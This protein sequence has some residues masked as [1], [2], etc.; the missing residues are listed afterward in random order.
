MDGR[1]R[2]LLPALAAL[3]RWTGAGA[4]ADGGLDEFSENLQAALP[5]DRLVIAHL[6]DDGRTFTIVAE[7]ALRGPVLH[8]ER[9]TGVVAPGERY[10][11][12]EWG[13][14][15]AFAGT[16]MLVDDFL[17]D[18]RYAS[19]N[20]YEQ[21]LGDAGFRAGVIVPIRA[22]GRTIGVLTILSLSAGAYTPA[23][24]ELAQVLA[25]LAAPAIENVVLRQREQ[26]RR[27]RLAA[28]VG[29]ART[30][31]ESLHARDIFDR[32]AGTIR[33]VLD[34]DIMGAGLISP[35]GREIEI[36]SEFDF[37]PTTP[38]PSRVPLESF[39][40]ADRVE[41]GET[42]LIHDAP[43][44]LDA[45]LPG[46]RLVIDGGGRSVLSV[47]LWFGERAGGALYLG[48]RRPYWFDASDAEI[49]AAIAAQVVVAIQHQR[50]TEEQ[51]RLTQAEGRARRL[52]E[53][54]ESLRSEL[55][56]RFALDAVI[57]RAPALRE[58]LAHAAKVAVTETTVLI[59]GE[60]GTGKELVARGIHAA[61]LRAD[62][63]FVAINC[64]ALPET[65]L[66]SELF[67]H[68]RGAFT[69]A[70]RQKPGRFELAQ[71]GTLFLDEVG[72]LS[73]AV[74][75]K[76]L[77]VL[78]EKEY[79]RVGGTTTL[80]ADVRVVAAS[81]RDLA[82]AVQRGHFREDLFYRLDVFS[83]HL[84]ALRD[85]GDDVLLLADHFVRTLAARMG[86]GEAGLSREAREALLAHSW[87]GN[88]RE[89][90][91]A[92]ERALI[93]SDAGLITAAQLGLTKPRT[94][95]RRPVDSRPVD[96]RPVDSRPADSR[97]PT[98]V[99]GTATT[100]SSTSVRGRRTE[101][102]PVSSG[103]PTDQAGHTPL[104]T[105]E[106]QLVQA[107]L[108]KARGNKSQAAALL[109]LSRSQLYTRLKRFGLEAG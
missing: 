69:G 13:M 83:V 14:R 45:A 42:V 77:R 39:S 67:G 1:V 107:A 18:P 73:P 7:H 24:R 36:V 62:G 58:Q 65:L 80:R 74:Q 59:T 84:P 91:N 6:D 90:G 38:T 22:G 32:L 30:L 40:F 5:H 53:R 29:I 63:P 109:G 95:D 81:N 47:P 35:S 79:E 28:L 103:P 78:Q 76:L 64:A 49:A 104:A 88:I 17:S 4:T 60:S 25:D 31:G 82:A 15:E 89:L 100:S 50:L 108:A 52:A 51:R 93:V 10:I 57:G 105:I 41:R 56:E 92:I 106:K 23:H 16:A 86:K 48:K 54:L 33:P 98:E 72:E 99:D 44:E 9:Y 68:E 26:R 61:S 46:D 3:T 66:E 11:V 96:S 20:R 101:P 12:R 8:R 21:P 71:G 75:A 34:F 43:T 55:G 85:R 97:T 87:P 27:E 19:P 70:D 2:D 102:E 37:A 94:S